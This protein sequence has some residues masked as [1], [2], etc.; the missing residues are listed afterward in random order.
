MRLPRRRRWLAVP[1]GVLLVLGL[2]YASAHLLTGRYAWARAVAWTESD[3][4]DQH[5][6]PARTIEAGPDVSPLPT[7]PEPAVLSA[8]VNLGGVG[9]DLDSFL[10]ATGT[11]AFLVVHHD[12]L[13]YEKYFQ[14]ADEEDLQTSFSAAKSFVSTLVGIAVDQGLLEVTDPIT[15][16]LPELEERDERFADITVRDLL[17]MSSG[18]H[19]VEDGLPW[20]DDALTYYGTDL[21]ELALT[22][23]HVEEP[24][25]ETWR[26]DNYHPLLLGL[27]LERVTGT[28]VSDFMATNLWKPLGAEADATWS[29]D[30]EASGFEKMESG[31]NARP[32]DFARFGLMMLHDGQWNGRRIL[33]GDWVAEAA[34]ASRESD[35]AEFYQY[36]WWVGPPEDDG[37]ASFYAHGKYGQL[38]GVFPAQDM[39]VVRLG[40]TD[41]GVDWQAWLRGLAA[42]VSG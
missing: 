27:I 9:R 12:R 35:P 4:G 39:V 33:S 11:R 5:R 6:F 42:R 23:T 37:E 18:L 25:G 1:L 32:R 10:E 20:S 13:V 2:L 17:T 16:Y 14:G 21:R 29:L 38:V 26:Y 41:G 34:A 40:S 31:L 22:H 15:A 30:S 36:L 24:A 8:P 3:I 28:S 19:Y 7:G